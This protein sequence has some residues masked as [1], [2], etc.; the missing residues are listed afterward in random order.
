MS[1]ARSPRSILFLGKADDARTERALDFCRRSFDR[2]DAYLGAWGD[3]WPAAASEWQGDYVVSYLSRW[4]VRPPVLQRAGAAAI[5]FHPASP[6]YPGIGCNNFALYDDAD[7]YGVTCHH[8]DA[9]VDTG[10]IVAVYRFPVFAADDV[11]SLLG[12]THDALLTLFFEVMGG[13]ARGEA[14]PESD[15]RWTRRPYT[16]REFDALFEIRADMDDA[17]VARRVRAVSFGP[18]QPYTVVHGRKFVYDPAAD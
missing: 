15:E 7:E 1:I 11:A 5:N 12:R 2:V 8:M 9:T 17:E 16:R 6:D 4:I 13:L 10:P 18:Y 3:T 14:L